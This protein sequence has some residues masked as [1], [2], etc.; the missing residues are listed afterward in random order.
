MG[1]EPSFISMART[2]SISS[3]TI[4][5]DGGTLTADLTLPA[6][7]SGLVVFCHGSGS[8]RFSPRNRAVAERLQRS[9][10]ATLLCD[11]ERSGDPSN[12][13]TLASLPPL[14]R[15][16]LI[17]PSRCLAAAPAPPWPWWRQPNGRSR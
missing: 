10:L 8:N 7:A 15:R 5:A 6:Q 4:P 17:A 14:Q 12:G 16:L 11:L 9:G 3:L 2:A 1:A 13:R